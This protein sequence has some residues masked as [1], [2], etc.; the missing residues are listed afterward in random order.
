MIKREKNKMRESC[1]TSVL[2]QPKHIPTHEE[3][4]VVTL[5]AYSSC[6]FDWMPA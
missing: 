6:Y 1:I 5:T 2:P 3:R 4:P